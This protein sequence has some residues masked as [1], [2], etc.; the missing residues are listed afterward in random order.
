MGRPSP[1]LGCISGNVVPRALLCKEKHEPADE[2][3]ATVMQGLGKGSCDGS[4]YSYVAGTFQMCEKP[5]QRISY[6]S[7]VCEEQDVA[8]G[9]S[10]LDI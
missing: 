3:A 9:P 4:A 8:P 2:T 6:G 5:S 1:L 7:H 10:W